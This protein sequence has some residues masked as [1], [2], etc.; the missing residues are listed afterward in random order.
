VNL[1]L[2]VG[3]HKTATTAIQHALDDEREALMERGVF[4]PS[5]PKIQ[6][7][8]QRL[9]SHAHIP[10]W[11]RNWSSATIGLEE[12]DDYGLDS[13]LQ[14]WI[15]ECHRANCHTLLLSSE[16]F[17]RASLEEWEAFHKSLIR[18]EATSRVQFDRIHL[19]YTNRDEKDRI[20]S[21]YAEMLKHGLAA[22]ELDATPILEFEAKQNLETMESL[23]QA[24]DERY[25]LHR[26]DGVFDETE[27]AGQGLAVWFEE[28][29]GPDI[30]SIMPTEFPT[31]NE[32]LGDE[33][34]REL[35]AFNVIN[36]PST[37]QLPDL[38]ACHDLPSADR[39]AFERFR[40]FRTSILVRAWQ[41][42]QINVLFR[43]LAHAE[44]VERKYH[45]VATE[46]EIQSTALE[47]ARSRI[48]DMEGSRSWRSTRWMRQISQA[49]K[50]GR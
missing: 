5:G 17:S 24:I 22:N 15:D 44:E 19:F 4:Y 10:Y 8:D 1:V 25:H 26:V 12:P 21:M 34:A 27:S 50:L 41:E 11:L 31:L 47:A 6:G 45:Q 48:E 39:Q 20:R 29:L 28:V 43:E 32:R 14:S 7:F 2:H 49:I 13:E 16:E 18:A 3:P 37:I 33:L 38:F 36:S 40:L 9:P 23:A 30:A 35:L 46:L 42:Q